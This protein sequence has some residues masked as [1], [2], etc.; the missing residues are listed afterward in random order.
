QVQF[1]FPATNATED[2][3]K[4]ALAQYGL[5]KPNVKLE[6]GTATVTIAQGQLGTSNDVT[7]VYQPSTP[8]TVDQVKTTLSSLGRSGAQILVFPKTG[9]PN[10]TVIIRTPTLT[11]PPP[12]PSPAP[13]V[14]PSASPS[15]TSSPAGSPSA[16]ESS[17][18]SPTPTG[19]SSGSAAAAAAA[20]APTK[21]PGKG[22]KASPKASG[23]PSPAPSASTQPSPSTEPSPTVAP[24]VT[25]SVTPAPSP[26]PTGPPTEA[27]ILA[28]IAKQAGVDPG[29]LT[30]NQLSK[31]D[32]AAVIAALADGAGVD[33]SKV[34][35]KEIG[36]DER[37]RLLSQL[38]DKSG[39]GTDEIVI[40]DVGPTWGAQISSKA[41][42]GLIIF[43]VLVTLYISFRFEWKMGVSALT[44]LA[45]D[46]IITAGIYA[47]VGRLVTP[48]TVIAILTILG[49]SLY[50][51]VVIFDRVKENTES[52]ALVARDGYSSV[53]NLSLNETLMRSVNT[54]LVVLLPILSLLLFGGDTL[55]DFAFALFIGVASGTY[56]SIFIAAPM[57]A[58]LKEREPRYAQMRA[59]AVRAQTRGQGQVAV[60]TTGGRTTTTRPAGSSQ[61]ARRSTGTT[62]PAKPTPPTAA[63]DSANGDG[64]ATGA[65]EPATS[66][67]SSSGQAKS[68]SGS[69][70]S[71]SRPSG[72]SRPKSK[73]R[74]PPAKR[75]RR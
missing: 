36:G 66:G 10:G 39:I 33:A 4:E 34:V 67:A 38:G 24:S 23:K 3:V 58:L 27:E 62:K 2:D 64:D 11:P 72:G 5:V 18:A 14:T 28:A 30:V 57:L 1:T 52:L 65:A 49:Y 69:R 26:S 37:A 63:A 44:A 59:R 16:V 7:I 48:E 21:A 29:Q 20:A 15:G 53:V 61:G 25:P 17:A 9:G 42:K 50:D 54:S 56:S 47:L 8:L 12:S 74:P 45:H 13:S 40:N 46:L 60:A 22:S 68:G 35:A 71:G 75:R 70:P 55:K 73:K 31:A 6:N 41:L 19:S 43:L 51:T 32:Q